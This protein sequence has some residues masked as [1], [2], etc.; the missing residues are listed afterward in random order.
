MKTIVGSWAVGKNAYIPRFRL[1]IRG[2]PRK[3]NG[4]IPTTEGCWGYELMKCIPN[5]NQLECLPS[6]AFL[7]PHATQE[8]VGRSKVY[9]RPIQKDL[10]LTPTAVAIN[11]DDALASVCQ[12]CIFTDEIIFSN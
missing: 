1:H 7:S 3:D 6:P 9:I 5:S 10:N 8:Y 11:T 4:S 2:I 12:L